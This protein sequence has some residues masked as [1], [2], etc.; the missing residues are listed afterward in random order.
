MGGELRSSTSVIARLMDQPEGLGGHRYECALCSKISIES[1][2]SNPWYSEGVLSS[3]IKEQLVP[4][5]VAA[6]IHHNF[7][8]K[9]SSEGEQ[10]ARKRSEITGE[11]SDSEI[12]VIARYLINY[13]LISMQADL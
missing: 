1:C 6:H 8:V 9:Q 5:D 7:S 11:E 10:A 2:S 12:M 13:D 4:R 3:V